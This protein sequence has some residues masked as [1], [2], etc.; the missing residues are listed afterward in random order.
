[1][2]SQRKASANRQ[3]ARAS[4]GPKTAIGRVRSSRN[5]LRHALSVPACSLPALCE[6]IDKLTVKIAGADATLEIKEL[7]RRVAEARIDVRRVQEARRRLFDD[8]DYEPWAKVD[9]IYGLL[10]GTEANLPSREE[11]MAVLEANPKGVEKFVSIL[12]EKAGQLRALDRYERRAL[13]R[14]K[15]AIR[16]LDEARR[17]NCK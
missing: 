15:F 9:Y 4:T 6:E 14:F 8:P 1:M 7:G 12:S 13:S 17:K 5:A 3:N 16:A 11:F 10:K 2:A